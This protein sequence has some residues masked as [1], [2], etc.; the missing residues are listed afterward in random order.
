MRALLT[1]VGMK[2]EEMDQIMNTAAENAKK[3]LVSF[4]PVR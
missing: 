4:A 2:Q 1:G 3:N